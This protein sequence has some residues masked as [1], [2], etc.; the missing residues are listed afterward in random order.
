MENWAQKD[1]QN[2]VEIIYSFGR[3]VVDY[4]SMSCKGRLN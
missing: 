1:F 4:G 3:D 2:G